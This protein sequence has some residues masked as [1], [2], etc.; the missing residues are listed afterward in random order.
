[1]STFL[2]F[3]KYSTQSL[4]SASSAR[5]RKAEHIIAR[6]RG[7]VKSMYALMGEHDLVMIVDLPG[8]DEAL[9]VSMGLTKLTGIAFTTLPAIGVSE[10]DKL[11]QEVENI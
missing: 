7:Q 11:L 10:F 2:F 8:I 4:K 9:K 1:M 6:F 5:T 3:G